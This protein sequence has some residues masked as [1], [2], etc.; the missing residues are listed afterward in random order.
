MAVAP[1]FPLYD[2]PID[3]LRWVIK[4]MEPANLFKLSLLS[5]RSKDLV[6]SRNWKAVRL[7]IN[8]GQKGIC[9]YCCF[10]PFLAVWC[11]LYTDN[12]VP[13]EIL[14]SNDIIFR[15]GYDGPEYK[16]RKK[17]FEAKDWL[18]HFKTT[19]HLKEFGILFRDGA[20]L[21]NIDYLYKKFGTPNYLSIQNFFGYDINDQ[22]LKVLAPKN[23]LHVNARSF[24]ARHNHNTIF[25]QTLD[26]L[27]I[28]GHDSWFS[29]DHLLCINAR[30]IVCSVLE[31]SL[32]VF[33]EFLKLWK[34][35]SNSRLE[36]LHFMLQSFV[37]GSDII[38][39][40]IA[41][42]MV[43]RE[44]NQQRRFKSCDG[45]VEACRG[46]GMDISR[47]DGTKATVC[48]IQRQMTV[49]LHF[50]VW[51]DHCIVNNVV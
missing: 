6:T 39:K 37:P 4:A 45:T 46:E 43:P 22:I 44:Q 23:S 36:E 5:Q 14:N 31:V 29:L 27:K 3:E 26:E 24:G 16:W 1:S 28:N 25:I 11:K 33:N 49:F 41:Y 48:I 51:H 50:Y 15:E 35:G 21:V 9:F 19:F 2:L 8:V 47:F 20:V 32:K 10:Y 38:M 40:G 12:I 13:N 34:S 30:R 17:G 18:D 42:R 7:E